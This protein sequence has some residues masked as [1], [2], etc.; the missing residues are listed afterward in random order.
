MLFKSLIQLKILKFSEYISIINLNMKTLILVRHA[1]SDWPENMRDFDRPLA[2]RGLKDAQKMAEYLVEENIAIDQMITS[3]ALRA[4]TTCSIFAKEFQM[5]FFEDAE[6]YHAQDSEFI[7][8]ISN[9]DENAR[10][11]AIF[12]HNEGISEFASSLCGDSLQFK[13]CAVAIFELYTETWT[14]FI[15][16]PITL[17]DYFTPKDLG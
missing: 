17:K 16:N 12:S 1:K 7:N 5:D 3:P 6:L 15:K 2:A 11:L 8:V 14:D 4:K 9:A 10:S 13:T